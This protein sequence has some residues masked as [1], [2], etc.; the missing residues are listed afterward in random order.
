MKRKEK[1]PLEELHKI[2]RKIYEET[3]KMS[4]SEY[5]KYIR[6]EAAKLKKQVSKKTA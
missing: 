5:V 6:E 2:R 3:K 4:A 1:D